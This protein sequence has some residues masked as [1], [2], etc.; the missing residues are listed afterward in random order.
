MS[1]FLQRDFKELSSPLDIFTVLY[2]E[3]KNKCTDLHILSDTSKRTSTYKLY[4]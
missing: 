4:M 2:V 1:Q 3:F